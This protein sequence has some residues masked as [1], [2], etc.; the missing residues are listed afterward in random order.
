[1]SNQFYR[2][3]DDGTESGPFSLEELQELAACGELRDQDLL[4][5]ENSTICVNA[6]RIKGLF[7]GVPSK[8]TVSGDRSAY[9]AQIA[10]LI[11]NPDA[12]TA[13]HSTAR[14]SMGSLHDHVGWEAVLGVLLIVM[15]VMYTIWGT[16]ESARF[17]APQR[18]SV[19]VP[20]GH[21]FF[22]TGPWSTLEYVLLWF[23]AVLVIVV[24][25]FGR[26]IL[27]SRK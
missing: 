18:M 5:T 21:F 13:R 4:R 20:Q 23:D 24:L 8:E 27:G 15:A 6:C 17:P 10:E 11:A 1:M 2:Q 9:E 19:Q 22:G 12:A 7:S 16:P 14:A 25:L 26:R 3:A